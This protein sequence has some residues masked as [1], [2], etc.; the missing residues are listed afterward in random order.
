VDF[1]SVILADDYFFWHMTS[2]L[3]QAPNLARRRALARAMGIR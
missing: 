2:P 3:G 1:E